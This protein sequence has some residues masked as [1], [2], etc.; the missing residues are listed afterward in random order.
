MNATITQAIDDEWLIPS[1]AWGELTRGT[2]AATGG[3]PRH[4]IV[5]IGRSYFGKRACSYRCALGER[6]FL[7][8]ADDVLRAAARERIVVAF[9]KS[10]DEADT[11]VGVFCPVVA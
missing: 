5:Q 11:F 1:K 10:A 7:A 2:F 4:A 3:P 6:H 9:T 8:Y